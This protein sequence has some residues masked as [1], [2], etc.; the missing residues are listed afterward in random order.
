MAHFGNPVQLQG[1]TI[2]DFYWSSVDSLSCNN[3]LNPIVSP[4]QTSTYILHV[5]DSNGCENSDTVKVI[6]DGVLYVP[7]TFTPN[8]DGVNDFFEIKGL[9]IKSFEL[10]I[11]NRWGEKIYYSNKMNSYWDGT[12]NNSPVQIDTYVWR[13]KYQDFQ[14]NHVDL[15]GHINILR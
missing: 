5:T 14:N 3:C 4:F 13:I 8:N 12:Y 11:F 9:E 2:H 1:N 15:N 7:N 10:W 6:L